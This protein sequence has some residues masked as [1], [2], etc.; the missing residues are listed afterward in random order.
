LPPSCQGR[1]T[2]EDVAIA[3]S[4]EEWELLDEAQRRLYHD[5]MLETLA[6]MASLGKAFKLPPCPE[7]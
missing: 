7:L 5:V 6:L 3:F 4:Q 2:F 1:V